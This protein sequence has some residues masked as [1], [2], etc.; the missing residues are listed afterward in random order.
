MLAKEMC[1]LTRAQAKTEIEDYVQGECALMSDDMVVKTDEDEIH[2]VTCSLVGEVGVDAE[3]M[4][5][6]MSGQ[7]LGSIANESMQKDDEKQAVSHTDDDSIQNC[8]QFDKHTLINLQQSDDSLQGIRDRLVHKSELDKHRVCF[9]VD[10]GL[11]MR[12]WQ[13]K[14]DNVNQETTTSRQHDTAHQIVLPQKCRLEVLQLA[15]DAML[16]GHLGVFKTK[17]RI[18]SHFYWPGI[19]KQVADYCRS[20]PVCQFID[21][22]KSPRKHPLCPLPVIQTPFKRMYS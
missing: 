6:E 15:H 17:D 22:T 20:C 13:R 11:I 5:R 1:I 7:E 9:Y 4:H 19:F 2:S 8:L 14:S 16:A 10:D 21:K 18:L 3:G 12:K